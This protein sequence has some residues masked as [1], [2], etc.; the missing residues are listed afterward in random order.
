[1]IIRRFLE[2][3][4]A[5]QGEERIEAA[6]AFCEAFV[7]RVPALI[8]H[9]DCESVLTLILDDVPAV[10]RVLAESLA[11]FEYAPRHIIVGLANECSDISIPVLGRSPLLTDADLIDCLAI[12][13]DSA[14]SAICLRDT[15]SVLVSAAIA[16]IGCLNAVSLLLKNPGAALLASSMARIAERFGH[17]HILRQLLLDRDDLPV[18]VRYTL[19][20]NISQ[21][22]IKFVNSCGWVEGSRARR[23][24][25]EASEQSVIGLS[26]SIAFCHTLELVETLRNKGQLT[27]SLLLRGLLCTHLN[28]FEASLSVLA[29]MPFERVSSLLQQKNGINFTAVYRRAKMPES[30][31]LTFKAAYSAA[32]SMQGDIS[33]VIEPR[34]SRSVVRHVLLAVGQTELANNIKIIG[35]LR[36][37]DVEAAKDEARY[38]SAQILSLPDIFETNTSLENKDSIIDFSSLENEL[39]EFAGDQTRAHENIDNAQANAFDE[40]DILNLSDFKRAA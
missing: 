9:P 12:G 20:V 8:D 24:M 37:L 6:Q 27:P 3:F 31:E 23:L 21:D 19:V 4:T 32:L 1:M 36:R 39:I 33:K 35:L 25:M 38:I 16:E 26:N 40:S 10:R 13:D 29:Q 15:V 34:I 22:L 30:L 5:S 2:W 17:D 14:Q 7:Q 18:S 28:L 11:G